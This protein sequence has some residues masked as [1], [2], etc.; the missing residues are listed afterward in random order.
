[1]QAKLRALVAAERP[2]TSSYYRDNAG[3]VRPRTFTA[4]P[5]VDRARRLPKADYSHTNAELEQMENETRSLV[6]RLQR[7]YGRPV[8][9]TVSSASPPHRLPCNEAPHSVNRCVAGK[10]CAGVLKILP[11]ATIHV[12]KSHMHAAW[13]HIAAHSLL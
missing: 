2:Q 11:Y 10:G 1:M 7:V 13:L 5:P 4:R 6:Q 12:L 8:A 3:I 9:A